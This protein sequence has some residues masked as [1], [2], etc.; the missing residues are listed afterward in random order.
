MCY[1]VNI[2]SVVRPNS[3]RAKRVPF[4]SLS[5]YAHC[6]SSVI[7]YHPSILSLRPRSVITPQ[8]CHRPPV[9]SPSPTMSSSPNS[10]IVTPIL[11][12]SPCSVIIPQLCHC[13]PNPSSHLCSVR[14]PLPK[15]WHRPPALSL[16][17][18]CHHPP[19]S[20][21][22]PLLCHHAP[23]SV[24]LNSPLRF[25]ASVRS[26]NGRLRLVHF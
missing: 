10:V 9:L 23:S 14:P 21:I 2:S 18:V 19:T 25:V 3:P 17:P 5:L 7:V 26:R 20:V 6:T 12:W 11:S 4:P 13:P 16:S 1:S 8:L 24:I 22:V 15:L